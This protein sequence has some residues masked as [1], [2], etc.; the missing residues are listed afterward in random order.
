[1]RLADEFCPRTGPPW[2]G[3][4][5]ASVAGALVAPRAVRQLEEVP[6]LLDDELDELDDELLDELEKLLDP[7]SELVEPELLLDA[8][9]LD[10]ELD[11]LSVR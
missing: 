3:L 4:I 1:M 6:E 5:A 11:R 7:E 2:V 10:D 9:V 8:G